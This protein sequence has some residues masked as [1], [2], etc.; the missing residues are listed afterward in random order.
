[1]KNYV[2][3][4][5]LAFFCLSVSA[6][7]AQ[8]SRV[9]PNTDGTV[10][11]ANQRPPKPAATPTPETEENA[12]EVNQTNIRMDSIPLENDEDVIKVETE[13]VTIPVKVLDRKGRFVPNLT[14]ENFK[15]FED[16]VE[17][18]IELFSNEQQPFTVALVLDMSYSSTFKINEI[19][20]AA[21][22]FIDQLRPND[23]V[24]VVSFSEEVIVHAEP[25]NDRNRLY[26]AI[27]QTKIASGTSLYEAVDL[28]INHKFNKIKGRKAV[29][30]FTDG[31][32]TTSRRAHDLSNLRDA[33]ET[34]ILFYP[35]QYDTFAD[36]QAIASRPVA[37]PP[38]PVPPTQKSPFPFPLP[39]SGIGTPS[40]Q[41]TSAEDYRKAGEY[42]DQ[43]AVRTGGRVY[44][45]STTGNLS[46]AFTKIASELREFYSLGYYPK[47]NAKQGESRKIKVSVDQ[48]GVA[49]KARDSYV[50]GK[51][52]K[53]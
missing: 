19:Q 11:K 23:K 42:L 44:K 7:F 46:D 49:V 3:A 32:D 50:V 2:V 40:T 21:I 43:I 27:K 22:E 5:L 45:A 18:Q 39:T 37:L 53:K 9:S 51:K 24:M 29:V 10:K 36:V 34:D 30:L 16:K 12:E 14:M 28:V 15:V 6:V 48:K 20:Q 52:A 25:T 33:L 1:M 38:Q 13:L 41:G 4:A 26:Q 35:I 31:V 47:E 17:Q 8:S